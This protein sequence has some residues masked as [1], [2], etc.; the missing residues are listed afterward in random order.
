VQSVSVVT[1]LQDAVGSPH[2][3]TD[4]DVTAA[5][6][7]DWTGRW[8]H[9]P[10]A[11]VRPGSTAEAAEVVRS[12][13]A[14]GVVVVPQGGN[15]GLVGASVP[16][17]E[18]SVVVSTTRL[19]EHGD[20]DLARRQVT[21]GAGMSIAEVHRLAAASGLGYGVDL[22]AR[23]SAT[24]GGTV[25]TNAGGVR[26]V[27]FGATRQNV[28]GVTAVLA[29]GSVVDRL[30]GLPK[31]SAGY[32]LSAL[33]VGSE[34]TLGLVTAVRLVLHDPLA[35]DRVTTLVGVP[36]LARAIELVGDVAPRE[37]LL[38]AEYFD[39]TGMRLVCETSGLP[40]PLGDRWPFYLL[41]ETVASPTFSD[42][43]DTAVDRRLWQYRERQPEAAASLGRLHSLDVAL[44]LGELDTFV[45]HLPDL[46]AGRRV[47]TFGH[48]AEGNLHVQIGGL[49]PDDES[50]DA[51]VFEVVAGLGGSISSEH[52]VG[53]A[54][55]RYLHL[56]RSQAELAAMRAVK[57][58]LDPRGLFNP[59]V[60]LS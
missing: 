54:K 43:E 52:G 22:G 57:Q 17:A 60:L 56:C 23:D 31:E 20:V 51:V 26:V 25:A 1:G 16:G 53:R 29:D 32:D 18:G 34:G 49:A 47:F 21:V 44:P 8:S 38:A 59:G 46:A 33:L 39:D 19:V 55:A 42:S 36:T 24:I 15:T 48:L 58:A 50:V 40:H 27:R 12:C 9:R 4:P 7:R 3:L 13:A 10:L 30:G 5:Y 28:A 35:D 2:V 6:G 45:S 14:A 11:V 37:Q 41:V